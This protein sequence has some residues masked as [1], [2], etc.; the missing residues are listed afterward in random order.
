MTIPTL[1]IH[2]TEENMRG[3][4]VTKVSVRKTIDV[5]DELFLWFFGAHVLY[6]VA[7][8]VANAVLPPVLPK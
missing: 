1:K 8:F 4:V 3:N 2:L 5:F 6:V 7:A